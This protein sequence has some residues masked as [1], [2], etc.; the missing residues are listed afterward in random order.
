MIYSQPLEVYH[1]QM[2]LA[3]ELSHV[4]KIFRELYSQRLVGH[5]TAVGAEII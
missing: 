1:L 4:A 2:I 5:L 3:K